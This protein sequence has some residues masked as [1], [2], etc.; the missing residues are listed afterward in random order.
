MFESE[1]KDGQEIVGFDHQK[2]T[3]GRTKGVG[4]H[5]AVVGAVLAR[6]EER[7]VE[8]VFARKRLLLRGRRGQR[9]LRSSQWRHGRE[10]AGLHGPM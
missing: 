8:Y 1:I 10:R 3:W 4:V 2:A 6:W 5:V 9:R 7:G